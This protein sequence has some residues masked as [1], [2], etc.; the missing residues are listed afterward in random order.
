MNSE[1]KRPMTV[2][3]CALLLLALGELLII[4]GLILRGV[5]NGC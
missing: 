4:V 1:F 2:P 3:E 5:G